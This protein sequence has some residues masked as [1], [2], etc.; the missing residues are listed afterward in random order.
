MHSTWSKPHQ[1]AQLV[2]QAGAF[3]TDAATADGDNSFDDGEESDYHPG[4]QRSSTIIEDDDEDLDDY[5]E[6]VDE[7]DDVDHYS[8]DAQ[9]V[10]EEVEEDD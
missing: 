10:A 8:D 9:E 5:G 6:I 4:P 1:F 7:D 2:R 3:A